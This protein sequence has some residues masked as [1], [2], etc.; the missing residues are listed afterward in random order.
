MAF[1][2]GGAVEQGELRNLQARGL[3]LRQVLPPRPAA[4]END[5]AGGAGQGRHRLQVCGHLRHPLRRRLHPV[6]A[7]AAVARR[8]EPEH[9]GRA[10][11]RLGVDLQLAD[12]GLGKARLPAPLRV[13]ADPLGAPRVQGRSQGPGVGLP[14]AEGR[15]AP[16]VEPGQAVLDVADL[17]P[18]DAL[19]QPRRLVVPQLAVHR[20]VVGGVVE[21]G[22]LQG[23]AEAGDELD[24]GLH[25]RDAAP[26]EVAD[27]DLPELDADAA[28]ALD[29]EAQVLLL[30]PQ[31][32]VEPAAELLRGV[33]EL[34][35]R[36][37]HQLDGEELVVGEEVQ[38]EAALLFA[39]E[40]PHL[41][42]ADALAVVPAAQGQ[43]LGASRLTGSGNGAARVAAAVAA[44]VD[45][46]VLEGG[47]EKHLFREFFDFHGV[48]RRGV[49]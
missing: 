34:Q 32:A 38:D 37:G 8:V 10:S 28:H 18:V 30:L 24:R 36:Q 40:P 4:D 16:A 45:Q 21:V 43:R 13:E 7:G 35:Q 12:E 22:L 49:R 42:E 17:V 1:E 41:A 27:R 5:V 33:G 48:V 14:L 26:E 39:V 9:R 44:A 20:G 15:V 25:R 46:L 11:P 3:Q 6:Q 29:V 2:A 31:D 23:E 19:H 47:A